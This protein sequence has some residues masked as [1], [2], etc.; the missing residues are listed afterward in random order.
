MKTRTK[1]P[2]LLEHKKMNRRGW[3]RVVEAFLS[4]LLIAMVLVIIMNNQ[5]I[6]AEDVS[7]GVYNYEIYIMRNI[8]L[9][10]SLRNDIMGVNESN[11]PSNWGN[12]SFPASVKN[13][14][15]NLTL[16]S[17]F[18]EAQICQTNSS[19][20]F[21]QEIKNNIYTQRVFISSSNQI[22]N[23]R[24]LKLFCWPK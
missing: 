22:Y 24:Q 18:C 19:C 15:Q 11:L 6:K 1:V 17:L 16:S 9:N 10:N 4:V 5:N 8:E 2:H 13:K 21:W 12:S 3:I 7:S 14:I 20:D 23:P